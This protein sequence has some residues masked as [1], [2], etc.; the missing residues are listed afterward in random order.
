V[1]RL[2]GCRPAI[3][4]N[5]RCLLQVVRCDEYKPS[6]RKRLETAPNPPLSASAK[7]RRLYAAENCLRLALDSTSGSTGAVG[8]TGLVLPPLRD[9]SLREYQSRLFLHTF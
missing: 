6:R 9:G 8:P 4:P 5:S 3:S 7:I 1:P 2:R